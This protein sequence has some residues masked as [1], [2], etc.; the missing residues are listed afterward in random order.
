MDELLQAVHLAASPRR[1]WY[2]RRRRYRVR[3]GSEVRVLYSPLAPLDLPLL[4][5]APQRLERQQV[6]LRSARR[7]EVEGGDH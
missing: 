1:R 4:A 5:G 3:K 2:G 7:R 6:G